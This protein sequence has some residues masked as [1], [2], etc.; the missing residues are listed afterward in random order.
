MKLY[1]KID[2]DLKIVYTKLWTLEEKNSL[3]KL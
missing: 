2:F 3:K 1:Y